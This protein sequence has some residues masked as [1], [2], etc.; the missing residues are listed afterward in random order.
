MSPSSAKD[1]LGEMCQL[2]LQP[3]LVLAAK[4][5]ALGSLELREPLGTGF[6]LILTGIREHSAGNTDIKLL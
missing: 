5:V 2:H 6:R 4:C 3:P 1:R